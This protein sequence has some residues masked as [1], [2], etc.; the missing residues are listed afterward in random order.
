MGKPHTIFTPED[1]DNLRAALIAKAQEDTRIASGAITGSAAVG[2]EDR[3]SDIDLAFGLVEDVPVDPVLANFTQEMYRDY[4]AI[5]HV[6][7]IS[8]AT[9]YRVF[10]LR[11]TLQVDLAFSPSGA[12]KAVGPTFHLVFGNPPPGVPI[13]RPPFAYGIGWAWLYA[14]HARSCIQRG[15]WW[16]AEYMI[17]GMRDAVLALACTRLDLPVAQARGVD[18]LPAAVTGPLEKSLVRELNTT[19]LVR[20][21]KAIMEA[22]LREIGTLDADL[23]DRLEGPLTMI[24]DPDSHHDTPKRNSARGRLCAP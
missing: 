9:T 1:R 17:S 23:K 14:L 8:E 6:D 5:H 4:D 15:Q 24:V 19:E 18:Q 10:L 22:L 20:A 21:F 12:L 3:W 13:P 16:R 11:N 2:R 7:L